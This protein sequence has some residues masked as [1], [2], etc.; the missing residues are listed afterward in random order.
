M[1]LGAFVASHRLTLA[2]VAVA[3]VASV[4]ISVAGQPLVGVLLAL[5][6]FGI[7]PFGLLAIPAPHQS[8]SGKIFA[9]VAGMLFLNL[10]VMAAVFGYF[11]APAGDSTAIRAVFYLGLI[12]LLGIVVALIALGSWLMSRFGF[13][14]PAAWA[15]VA[16]APCALIAGLFLS[17]ARPAPTPAMQVAVAPPAPVKVAPP[18]PAPVPT[19]PVVALPPTPSIDASQLQKMLE[20]VQIVAEMSQVAQKLA[21]DPQG[22]LDDLD[23]LAKKQQGAADASQAAPGMTAPGAGQAAPG[24]IGLE[25]KL[26]GMVAGLNELADALAAI[27]DESGSRGALGKVR[28]IIGRIVR[29]VN[30]PT[31]LDSQGLGGLKADVVTGHNARHQ[32]AVQRVAAEVTRI[33][34]ISGSQEVVAEVNR[35]LAQLRAVSPSR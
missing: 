6:G 4:T 20:Q 32:A 8:S 28:E 34:P 29:L 17:G 7:A 14:R 22:G 31:A 30:A 11:R 16:L 25:Q 1:G 3:L 15:Y 10:I 33:G 13:F 18:A 23:R 5:A 26:T 9:A 35:F 12:A 27:R 19:P 24:S 2:V 21:S